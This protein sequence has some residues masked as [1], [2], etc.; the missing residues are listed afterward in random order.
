MSILTI[1]TLNQL[2]MVSLPRLA[3]RQTQLREIQHSAKKNL[4]RFI[5]SGEGS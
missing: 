1:K 3:Q 2:G 5:H 4:G